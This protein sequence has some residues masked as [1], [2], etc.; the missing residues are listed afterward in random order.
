M[1]GD[2][3]EVEAPGG[4]VSGE[5]G[6]PLAGAVNGEVGTS[7]A[8]A[9]NGEAGVLSA[10]AVNGEVGELYRTLAK[11]LERI[12][13]VDVIAP[14][15]V[16]EDAC[17]FAWSRLVRHSHRVRRDAALT[18][19]AKTAVH[20]AVKL[21]RRDLREMSLD[22]LTES[23]HE[24]ELAHWP[25]KPSPPDPPAERLEHRERL[26]EVRELPARQQRLLWLQALGL[27]YVEIASHEGYTCRTVERQ[28]LRARHAL[29]RG[30][31]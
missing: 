25:P 10:G 18:W 15:P 11:P 28:L 17:Q 26:R 16:I 23:A 7:S 14:D 6:D 4:A 13:R 2:R 22:A 24:R 27:S 29:R 5:A 31:E 20:E 19:L 9:V 21:V 30:L 8:G 3:S 12:V 1:M